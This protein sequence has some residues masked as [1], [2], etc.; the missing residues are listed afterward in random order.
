MVK[1]LQVAES[2][3]CEIASTLRIFSINGK[4]ATKKKFLELLPA[5]SVVHIGTKNIYYRPSLY[6]H[7]YAK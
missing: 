3:G 1:T 4:E 6:K 5:A 2:E 7:P